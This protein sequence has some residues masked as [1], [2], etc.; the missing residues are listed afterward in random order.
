MAQKLISYIRV[1]TKRQGQSGLGLEAQRAAVQHH[2]AATGGTIL[3]EYREVE[4]GKRADRVELA[5]ALAA[6]RIHGAT[7]VVAKLDRLA[8]NLAFLSALMESGVE[9]VCVDNPHATRF[10]IHILAAVAEQ[11]ARDISVRTV[12]ALARS[13]KT[14]GGKRWDI[15]AAVQ[16][17]ASL[18]GSAEKKRLA[19]QRARDLAPILQTLATECAGRLAAIA[20][21]LNARSIPTPSKVGKWH[22]A[23]VARIQ[24]R[25]AAVA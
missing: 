21:A 4:S 24:A 3:E 8:R 17:R 11:E 2:A 25:A 16:R 22:A 1:S 7:L 15:P 14:L 20:D 9:F 12:A 13:R 18:A 23:T 10:T 5:K 6:C 19:D